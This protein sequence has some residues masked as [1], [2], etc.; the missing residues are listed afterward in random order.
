MTRAFQK[1][2]PNR[3]AELAKKANDTIL[4]VRLC[5]AVIAAFNG[6]LV[7][8]QIIESFIAGWQARSN[9]KLRIKVTP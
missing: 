5:D 7:E 9:Q 8:G 3:G 4:Q 1:M 2:P 6:G